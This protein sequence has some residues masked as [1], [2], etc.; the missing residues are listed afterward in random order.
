MKKI[1]FFMAVFF[2]FFLHTASN[3]ES[4]AP[5]SGQLPSKDYF[6]AAEP[7]SSAPPSSGLQTGDRKLLF[8]RNPPPTE[9]TGGGGSVG[10]APVTN[11]YWILILCCI[12]YG[13]YYRWMYKPYDSRFRQ[14]QRSAT[15]NKIK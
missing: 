5:F 14:K 11:C 9:G 8:D 4:A 12:G 10:E 13:I 1:R 2:L 3:Q 6:R 7:P 15:I